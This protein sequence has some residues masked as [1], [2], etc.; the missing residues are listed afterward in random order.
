MARRARASSADDSFTPTAHDPGPPAA[1]ERA[2][3]LEPPGPAAIEAPNGTR[4]RFGTASWTDPTIVRAGVFYPRDATSAEAR[5]KYYASQFS[6]VEVDASYYALP[7]RQ[8]VEAWADRTPDTFRFDIKAHALMTGQPSEVVRL[9][10][11]IREAL[12]AALA[13][14]QRLYAKDLP[15]ELRD[16]VWATFLDALLPLRETDKLGAVLMQYP[17]WFLPG[18]ASRDEILDAHHRF[19]DVPFTVELRNALWFNAR[20]AEH[21]LRFFEDHGIPFVM[22]DEPQGLKSSVPPV[23][24]VTA[25]R[26]AVIRFHGRRTDMWEK[27]GVT[28]AEKFRYLYDAKELEEWA[29]RVRDIAGRASEVHVVMNNCY[30]NY[31]TTNAIEIAAMVRRTYSNR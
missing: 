13:A 2:S 26:L 9:P 8:T 12:P 6:I 20:N 7:V 18:H 1:G 5:L 10:A 24:A 11:D 31:G 29:P 15:A 22:V 4:I 16:A 30:A 3:Q 19:G 27:P 17:K 23:V 14:K 21:T 25:P 28:T